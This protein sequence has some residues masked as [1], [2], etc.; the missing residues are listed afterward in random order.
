MDTIP[1]P[2]SEPPAVPELPPSVPDLPPPASGSDPSKPSAADIQLG[3]VMHLLPLTWLLHGTIGF[4][5]P[6]GLNIIAPLIF[7]LMKKNES[8][9]LDAHGKEVVNFNITVSIAM[10]ILYVLFLL[11]VWIIIGFL[12]V[13]LML[14]LGGVWLVLTVIGA[15]KASEGKLYRYPGTIRLIQ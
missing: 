11:L 2:S 10:M 1:P 7:W 12:F 13:P 6:V 4:T 15:I 14:L 5:I 8:P 9:Y 3:I